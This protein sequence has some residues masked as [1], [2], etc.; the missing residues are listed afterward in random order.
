MFLISPKSVNSPYCEDEV[1][2]ATAQGKRFITLL[3]ESLDAESHEK[4]NNLKYLS[5]V[6]WIDCTKK[7]FYSVFMQLIRQIDTDREHVEQ[8]T[9]WQEK[10]TEAK[11]GLAFKPELLL[12]Q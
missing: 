4:F 8:H 10:A 2:F 6:Q 12:W 9:K 5:E 11:I 3:V 7:D 1:K